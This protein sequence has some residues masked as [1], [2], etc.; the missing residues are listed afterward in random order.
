[1]KGE[2]HMKVVYPEW[3]TESC[4]VQKRLPEVHYDVLKDLVSEKSKSDHLNI[5]GLTM[6]KLSLF[7]RLLT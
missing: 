7:I 1:M 3:V 6:L 2:Y 5:V 4:K